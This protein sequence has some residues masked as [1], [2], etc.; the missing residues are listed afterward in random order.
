MTDTLGKVTS[1]QADAAWVYK[2]DAVA[3]GDEIEVIEIPNAEDFVNDYPAAVLKNA[4]N[5]EAAQA[6]LELLRS[7]AMRSVWED[8]GFL[9][10]ASK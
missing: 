7:E 4:A 5:A 1:G 2:T 8:A 6:V 9:P 3:A 10:A